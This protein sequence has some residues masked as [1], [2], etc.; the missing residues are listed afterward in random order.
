MIGQLVLSAAR[1][2]QPWQARIQNGPDMAR[3]CMGLPPEEARTRLA[4]LFSLCGAA[5]A[6]AAT[7]A[8]GLPEQESQDKTAACTRDILRDHALDLLHTWPRHLGLAPDR[9]ALARTL[10]ATTS[11][12]H[13]E[14]GQTATTL[15]GLETPLPQL[16]LADFDHWLE[17]SRTTQPPAPLAA[18]LAPLQALVPPAQGRADLPAPDCADLA[19]IATGAQP[20]ARDAS[21]LADHRDT[22]LLHGLIAREGVSLFVRVVARALDLLAALSDPLRLFTRTR[23]LAA[24]LPTEVGAMPQGRLGVARAA[25]GLLVHHATIQNGRVKAYT[26]FSPTGWHMAHNGLLR[27]CLHS[28]PTV[29]SPALLPALLLSAINPCVPTHVES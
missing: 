19:A 9:A 27:R 26:V 29:D 12:H 18:V 14:R 17:A 21:I 24:R 3:T 15:T 8:L 1:A 10:A 23:A 4:S 25:R 6:A 13:S 7:Q 2:G 20:P 11:P 16:A 28:L 22:P 5:H